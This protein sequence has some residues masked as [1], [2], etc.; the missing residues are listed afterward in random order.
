[1]RKTRPWYLLIVLILGLALTA[2][3]CGGDDD[4]DA[5]PEP[6]PAPA[7][8]AQA[9]AQAEEQAEPEAPAEPDD[10]KI[11]LQWVT[12]AQFAGY[13]AA[14]DQ[15][16]YEEENLNVEIQ[17]G[18]PDIL[19]VQL[20][21][22]GAAELA[23]QPFAVLLSA[24]DQG[25]DV[26]AVAQVFERSAYRLV[27]WADD[28][29][30]SPADWA[31]LKIG[32]WAGHEMVSA[33]INKFGF[34]EG[35]GEDQVELIGQGF[36]MQLLLTR[37]VDMASAMIYNEFAQLIEAGNPVDQFRVVDFADHDTN[38]LEDALIAR[39]EWLAE[40]ANQDVVTR[41]LRASAKG[42]AHCA[43]DPAD[44]VEI[45]LKYGPALPRPHQTWMMNEINKL[46][47]PS[48]KGWGVI[49]RTQA[50]R[51][52]GLMLEYEVISEPADLDSAYTN[53][54]VEAALEGFS[55]ADRFR[56][57][58]TPLDLDVEDLLPED[59]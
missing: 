51:T 57:D 40:E 59:S 13:F 44:C 52:A 7:A 3:A 8:A 24:R 37:Q 20:V 42:W 41:F 19:P 29:I 18:G 4:D 21:A 48:T 2:V 16:F 6:A 53:E 28:N 17:P 14:L 50:E 1:M 58:Y 27:S 47:W 11:V 15:G 26:V 5:A 30:M 10:V 36:D 39:G 45:V 23:V 12:Q 43:D 34:T 31:G 35:S 9:Q 25:I 22:A 54:Y 55:D 32:V 49:D 33:T 46:M 56:N 38:T